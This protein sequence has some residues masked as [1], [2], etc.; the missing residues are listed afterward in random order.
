MAVEENKAETEYIELCRNGDLEGVKAAL[1]A[2]VD[3][4]TR[5]DMDMRGLDLFWLC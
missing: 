5:E 3:V 2:G 1:L 4:N